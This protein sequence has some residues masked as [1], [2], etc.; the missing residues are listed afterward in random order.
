MEEAVIKR[1][2]PHS[3]EA[4]QGVIGAMLL[5]HDAI[6]A[7][8]EILQPED[9]YQMQYGVIFASM[10][11]L[12]NEGRPVD[13]ITL[14]DRLKE[15]DLPPEV[16]SLEFVRDL[17]DSVPTSTNVRY[18]AKIVYEKAVLRRLIRA[19][20]EIASTCYAGKERLDDILEQTEKSIF[21]LVQRGTTEEFEPIDRVALRVLEKIE[22]AAKNKSAVTGIA[23]GYR[24]LDQLLSGL[25]PSDLVLI[26]ARPS[27]GKTAF[28][29]N[30]AQY[31]ALRKDQAVLIFSLE[32]NND[33]LVN[34]LFAME[35]GVSAQQLR[36][37]DLSDGDWDR[38]LEGVS[39]VA[40]SQI[41]I[42]DTPGIS[43]A[44]MR[45]RCRKLML[46]HDIKLVIVDYLQLMAGSGRRVESR[47]LEVAE[48]SRALKGLARELKVP[49]VAL[50]QLS[51]APE[52]R[53]GDHRPV[54]SD[55]R[56]SGAIE[57]DADVVMFLYRDEVYNKDTEKKN[58]LEVIVAK[59]RNGPLGTVELA[60][61]PDKQRFMNL[62]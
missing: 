53:S 31:C 60:W 35:S 12:Y 24:D 20:E 52:T 27:M 37:G 17:L 56:D 50:S 21:G 4:E 10:V 13:L 11:E 28:A 2:M 39:T 47:Q 6:V 55:L 59:Q 3:P 29:L 33:Q 58:R 14:Q 43:I 23:T 19:S 42:A 1:I 54:L 18:Y 62:E 8:A 51:R 36:T 7:A 40:G 25:Q 5:D 41:L 34:R 38:L 30:I 61:L 45:R 16:Y 22:E 32:M 26:A 15:K 46:E 9:F 48:I 49:V 57:Q 44:E